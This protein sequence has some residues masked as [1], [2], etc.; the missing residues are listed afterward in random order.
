MF[1]MISKKFFGFAA[2]LLVSGS[3]LLAGAA[4]GKPYAISDFTLADFTYILG[5]VFLVAGLTF[6]IVS[7]FKR[8]K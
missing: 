2:A 1:L 8:D 6:M 4:I 5:L 3:I 7:F